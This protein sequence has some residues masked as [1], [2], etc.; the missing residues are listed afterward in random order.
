MRRGED[1]HQLA[2]WRDAGCRNAPPGVTAP[3]FQQGLQVWLTLTVPPLPLVPTVSH[4]PFQRRS[5]VWL[6]TTGLPL[7]GPT[8][9]QFQP[10]RSP[11]W[12]WPVFPLQLGQ[13]APLSLVLSPCSP[14]MTGR[15]Q[16][17]P[18][19]NERLPSILDF[20]LYNIYSQLIQSTASRFNPP[21]PGLFLYPL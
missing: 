19:E 5:P 18:F 10:P 1:G 14:S 7:L 9:S 4:S 8:V 12:L 3:L 6:R 13:A 20:I 16:L 15:Q 17:Q 11:V 21:P 2:V